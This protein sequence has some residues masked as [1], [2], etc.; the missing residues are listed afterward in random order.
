MRILSIFGYI[1]MVGG[2]LYLVW[3]RN[4][5]ALSPL[6]LVTQTAGVCMV[7]WARFTL[8]KRSFHVM[9]NPTAGALVMSGPYR[10]IRHPLYLGF[11]L[12]TLAGI[13]AHFSLRTAICGA[14]IA[15]CVVL[16]IFCE[17]SLVTQQYPEYQEYAARTWRLVPFVF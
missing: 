12:F 11:C 8:G 16:R 13:A 9:A 6:V 3:T 2:L 4:F 15:G 10:R 5:F 1:G 17:E 14:F 7:L